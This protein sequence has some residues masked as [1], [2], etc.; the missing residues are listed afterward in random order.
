ANLAAQSPNRLLEASKT[1]AP[2]VNNEAATALTAERRGDI[3]MAR[4]M[5][6][7]AVETYQQDSLKN[8]VILNKI[9]IAY[10]QMMQ[11]DA[12]KKNY[13][14]AIKLNREYAEALNNLGTIYYARKSYRKAISYY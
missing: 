12:A 13:E 3:M 2:S 14:Q 11:L 1:S 9:G 5:Y 10:H 7:E 4:K 8:P 6:R